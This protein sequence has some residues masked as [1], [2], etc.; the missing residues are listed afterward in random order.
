MIGISKYQQL[1]KIKEKKFNYKKY[2]NWIHSNNK[3]C[4]ICGGANIE[5]HHITDLYS[6]VL[7]HKQRRDDKRVVTLCKE[8]HKEGKDGIHILSKQDFYINVMSLDNLL[9]HSS[10]LL[11]EYESS[12]L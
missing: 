4:V 6:K 5:I 3:V 11:Q 10:K 9:T 7:E 2:A 12:T 1:R 8:H